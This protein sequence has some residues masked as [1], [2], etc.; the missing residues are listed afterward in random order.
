[1]SAAAIGLDAQYARLVEASGGV[2]EAALAVDD[3]LAHVRNGTADVRDVLHIEWESP[4]VASHVIARA[5]LATLR[6]LQTELIE[7]AAP[8][9][10]DIVYWNRVRSADLRVIIASISEAPFRYARAARQAVRDRTYRPILPLWPGL[11]HARQSFSEHVQAIKRVREVHADAIG[12][13][14]AVALP[15]SDDVDLSKVASILALVSIAMIEYAESF[16]WT[17]A[18]S[19]T[20]EEARVR[21]LEAA[22]AGMSST[23]AHDA[24]VAQLLAVLERVDLFVAGA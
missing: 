2:P 22:A 19:E 13:L 18:V 24:T 23:A 1:M 6:L 14:S 10:E 12:A 15:V 17:R 21:M 9:H 20:G 16:E 4:E 3:R 8:L 7:T 5:A 11:A